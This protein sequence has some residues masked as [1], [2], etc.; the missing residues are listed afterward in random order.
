MNT[1]NLY[2]I[3]YDADEAQ[4]YGVARFDDIGGAPVRAGK[5]AWSYYAKRDDAVQHI[6]QAGGELFEDESGEG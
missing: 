6:E 4:P 3:S 5:S 2:V 1:T